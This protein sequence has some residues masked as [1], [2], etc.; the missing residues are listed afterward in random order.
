VLINNAGI[1]RDNLLF[2]MTESVWDVVLGVY[3]ARCVPVQPCRATLHDRA[4]LGPHRNISSTSALGNRGQANHSA[5]KAGIQ[6]FTKTLA[7]E[8]GGSVS[9]STRSLPVSSPPR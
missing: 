5:A 8:L 6:G 7:I 4:Q 2:R 3:P 1:T 9:Q